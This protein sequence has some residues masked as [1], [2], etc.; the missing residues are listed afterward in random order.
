MDRNIFLRYCRRDFV[1]LTALGGGLLLIGTSILIKK[2][3]ESDY[4]DKTSNFVV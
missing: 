3:P 1:N 4:I 2:G